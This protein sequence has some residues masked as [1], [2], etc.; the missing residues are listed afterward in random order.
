MKS[1]KKDL[2]FYKVLMSLAIPIVLQNLLVASLNLL[3]SIMVGNLGEKAIA[4]VGIANQY[5]M[6]FFNTAHGFIMGAGIFVAQYW[7]KKDIKNIYKFMGLSFI[8]ALLVTLLFL[9]GAVFFPKNIMEIF[10]K[11]REVIELGKSYLMIVAPSYILTIATLTFEMA[12]RGT[13]NTKIPM[14]ASLIGLVVN[15]ILNYI[16]IFGKFGMLKLGVFGAGL[17]TLIAR[18]FELSFILYKIYVV[19]KNIV[20]GKLKEIFDIEKSMII[21]FLKTALPVVFNDMMWIGGLTVYFLAFSKLGTTATATMQISNTVNNVFNIFGIG[22]ALA[23]GV[24]VGNRIGAQEDEIAKI[25]ARKISI[26]SVILGIVIGIIFFIISPYVVKLFSVE[27]E[28][29]K[30]IVAVLRVMAIVLPVRFFGIMQIIGIL[31]GGGDVVFAILTEVVA[32]WA[33]GV[34]MSFLGVLYFDFPI[35][36]VY[37]MSCLE[38]PFKALATLPRLFSGKWIKNLVKE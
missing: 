11:D 24:M 5:Y 13:G 37:A 4:S 1:M 7:G 18:C 31:R 6:L 36:Y 27:A 30:S 19:D 28:T 2:N 29:K 35:E 3:D 12:L 23:G 26:F 32:V 20:A 14:Y 34:P 22:I 25:E 21:V 17:G 33:V 15:G 38:E 10:T 9:A 16:F 8:F